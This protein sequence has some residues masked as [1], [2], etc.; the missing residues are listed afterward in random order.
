MVQDLKKRIEAGQVFF[1]INESIRNSKNLEK[2]LVSS[3]CR[4]EIIET[5]KNSK[6]DLEVLEIS[7][8]EISEKLDLKFK[9]EVFG[10]KK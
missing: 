1:G 8:H 7:K 2:A 9:C 6:V 10:I 3:D 5:L 4:E